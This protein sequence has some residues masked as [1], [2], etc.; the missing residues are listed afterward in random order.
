M[1]EKGINAA[2]LLGGAALAVTNS[3]SV[4]RYTGRGIAPL[5]ELYESSECIKGLIA[6]DKVVG[7]A[8]AFIYT[9]LMPKSVCA[10]VMSE[11]A[12][13]IL[14]E[15]GIECFSDVV[16]KDVLNRD[17]TRLCPMETAVKDCLSFDEAYPRIRAALKK[18]R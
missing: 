4:K 17:K 15:S 6:A 9:E 14:K 12:A 3:E 13:A 7:K 16:V 8:A 2:R 18:I 1:Q 10:E 5:L 11:G